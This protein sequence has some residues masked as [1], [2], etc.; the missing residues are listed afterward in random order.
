MAGQS[1]VWNLKT[2]ISED[3]SVEYCAGYIFVNL[4]QIKSSLG[5]GML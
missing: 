2:V 4:T 3:I 5:R 1:M